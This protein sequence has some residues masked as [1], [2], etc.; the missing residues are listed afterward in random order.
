MEVVSMDEKFKVID[1][2]AHLWKDPDRKQLDQIAED[3]IISQIW[4]QA[5]ECHQCTET[6][7][8][9]SCEDVLECAKLYPDLILPFGYINWRKDAS[10]IDR[11]KESGF[12]GLKAIR[13]IKNYDDESYYPLYERAEQLG[14]P[15][16]FHVGIIAKRTREG[17][18]DPQYSPGPIR[19]RPSM[20]D[21]IA[22]LF[23][24][25]KIIQG[26]MGVPW[27]NELFESLWYYPNIYCSING[28]IDWKWLMENLDRRSEL[29]V[30]FHQK[31]MWATD[32][33]YGGNIS[34]EELYRC[35][36]FMRDF[37]YYAGQTYEW[38]KYGED[39]LYNNAKRFRDEEFFRISL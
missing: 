30:P 7:R 24:R 36:R 27:C 2:H 6:Y 21:T 14:M 13:P 29:D 34:T 28:L 9:A 4:I 33:Y 37:Y 10:Q 35:A 20:L 5:H 22:A 11:L 38:G 26:H 17:L 19:M 12:F 25:L 8:S 15:I 18:T 3:G 1:T 31:V 23:P 16:L 39:C 32:C